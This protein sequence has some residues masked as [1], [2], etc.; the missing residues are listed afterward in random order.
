MPVRPRHTAV[1]PTTSVFLRPTPR[2]SVP[3]APENEEF[4]SSYGMPLVAV[5]VSEPEPE[6]GKILDDEEV[7]SW[8][9]LNC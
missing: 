2:R 7:V 5:F 3:S 1:L 9:I 6:V 8:L 4:F